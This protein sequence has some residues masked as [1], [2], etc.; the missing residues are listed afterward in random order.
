LGGVFLALTG[1]E[2]LYADMGHVGRSPIRA[3]WYCIVLP[4]LALNYTGQVG[5]FMDSPDL[6]LNPFFKLAPYWMLYPLVGLG[7]V[8]TIIA[9]QAIITGSFSM[10]RQPL[11]WAGFRGF[12]SLRPRLRNM[13]K[14]TY[15]WSIGQ[16]CSSLLL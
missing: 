15:R 11:Q 5:N 4:A 12:G 10:T 7:T 3:A 16:R 8:A 14:S 13:A 9:S 2:A 6:E 1:A